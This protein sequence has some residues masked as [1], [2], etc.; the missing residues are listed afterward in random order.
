[1]VKIQTDKGKFL[2]LWRLLPQACL[3]CFH[4]N[5]LTIIISKWRFV[6]ANVFLPPSEDTKPATAAPHVAC[7]T[8]G[9][10][11][12]KTHQDWL[13]IASRKWTCMHMSTQIYWHVGAK[14]KKRQAYEFSWMKQKLTF[15]PF[16]LFNRERVKKGAPYLKILP[17]AAAWQIFHNQSVF[18]T[19]RRTV[20][21][22]SASSIT[23]STFRRWQADSSTSTREM[24]H[25]LYTPPTKT[26]C[27]ICFQ[28]HSKFTPPQV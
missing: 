14:K 3:K 1:M 22:S 28:M 8:T 23:I 6:R 9:F 10:V 27:P 19:G 2:C 20:L 26:F 15:L 21:I 16:V 4:N 13:N 5:S 24:E 7:H 11:Y 17:T 18:C 12:T 25:S